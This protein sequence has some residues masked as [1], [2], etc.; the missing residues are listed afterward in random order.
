MVAPKGRT[1]SLPLQQK[2][3]C[4]LIGGMAG[5]LPWTGDKART[6]KKPKGVLQGGGERYL[7]GSD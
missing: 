3:D 1:E 5:V 7:D 6:I 2:N 4:T